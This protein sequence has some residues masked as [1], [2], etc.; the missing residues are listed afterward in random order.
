MVSA[1]AS[2]M[3]LSFLCRAACE[4]AS[5]FAFRDT[6]RNVTMVVAEL[7]GNCQL[8]ASGN[9]G[10]EHAHPTM[11]SRHATKNQAREV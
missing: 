7:I 9:N 10:S 5:V 11:S 2:V 8:S 4:R 3:A 1:C 6:S